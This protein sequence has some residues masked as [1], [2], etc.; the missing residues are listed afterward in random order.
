MQNFNIIKK[1]NGAERVRCVTLSTNDKVHYC[2][3]ASH[4]LCKY[5]C[6]ECTRVISVG[7]E[8]E[9]KV[10][11]GSYLI[12]LRLGKKN[13]YALYV[14]LNIVHMDFQLLYISILYM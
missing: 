13:Q 10:R 9:A 5:A 2:I 4:I 12:Q 3:A 11:T 6:R 7:V 1:N 14:Y 8:W